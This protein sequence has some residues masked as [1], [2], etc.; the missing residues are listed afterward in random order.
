M[1]IPVLI[2]LLALVIVV[3][4]AAGVWRARTRGVAT[5]QSSIMLLLLAVAAAV[6]VWFVMQGR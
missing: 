6:L 2:G 5:Q 1:S 4:G 3:A